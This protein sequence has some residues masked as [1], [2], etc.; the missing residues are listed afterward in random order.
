[1]NKPLK[2]A[3][4]RNI[5]HQIPPLNGYGGTDRYVYDFVR[6]LGMLK[7][8][9]HL[10]SA[11]S[12]VN[13]FPSNVTLHAK[14]DAIGR[15]FEEFG[16]SQ[17]NYHKKTIEHFDFTLQRLAE[18]EK[19]SPFDVINIRVDSLYLLEEA[20][21][22][23]GVE[24]LIYS[25]HNVESKSCRRFYAN[26]VLRCTAHCFNHKQQHGNGDNIS[27]VPYGINFFSY[28]TGSC[29][30][31]RTNDVLTVPALQKLRNQNQ[32]YF[33][34]V[35]AIGKHK[36]TISSIKLAKRFNV[37]LLLAG[38]PFD[39]RGIVVK[40][41]FE[42]VM[43]EVDQ[44]QIIYLGVLGERQKKEVLRNASLL[45][46][47]SGCED[48]SWNEPFGRIVLE[49]NALGTPVLAFKAGSMIDVIEEGVNGYF[50]DFQLNSDVQI[51]RALNLARFAVR[52]HAKTKYNILNSV[53]SF[54]SIC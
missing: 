42:K 7:H 23:F 1:M 16:V 2:V 11:R 32:S 28:Q 19:H 51:Q 35:G 36:G 29:L 3:V 38:P 49:A 18:L 48:S 37:P 13:A 10:F 45:L 26:H 41:Y 40:D 8:E 52:E 43:K 20:L 6:T 30:Q 31:T 39:P 54:I 21:K 34:C 24:R 44:K 4:I 27:V 33:A 12:S 50:C 15:N 46:F 47:A 25:L 14:F 9:V 53:K 5:G 17:K 22:R